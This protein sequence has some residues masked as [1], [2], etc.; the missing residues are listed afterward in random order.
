MGKHLDRL[1][2]W[3]SDDGRVFEIEKLEDGTFR[4]EECCENYFSAKFTAEELREL[5]EEIIEVS[6]S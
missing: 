2:S 3:A 4:I 6:R 5:A 1:A